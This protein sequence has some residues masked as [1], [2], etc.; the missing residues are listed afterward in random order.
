MKEI[1]GRLLISAIGLLA[2][3]LAL[4]GFFSI[5]DLLKAGYPALSADGQG[6]SGAGGSKES[7]GPGL[8]GN[9]TTGTSQP[10]GTGQS[11]GAKQGFPITLENGLTLNANGSV[12]GIGLGA[13][14][15]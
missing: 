15:P 8:S 1:R 7:P 4:T 10:A 11:T 14:G 3:I 9:R 5:L 2:L 6:L 12:T 13:K